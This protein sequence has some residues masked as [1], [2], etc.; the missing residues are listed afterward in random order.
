MTINHSFTLQVYTR[1]N[2]LNITICY[3]TLLKIVDE[4]SK[5]H[6]KP[7]S[8]WLQEGAYVKFVGDNVDKKQTVRDIRSDH[9]STLHH[10]YSMLAIKAR[11]IPPPPSS[12]FVQPKLTVFPAQT[13]LPTPSDVHQLK[14]NLTILVSCILCEHFTQFR[15]M[16]KHVPKH[17][18]HTYS[19]EMSQQSDT[20]VID[21]LHKN[22]AKHNDMLA[23]MTTMQS[24]LGEHR[25]GVLSGGDQLTCERQRGSKRHVMDGDTPKDRLDVLHP[26]IEDWHALQ[27]FLKVHYL[28]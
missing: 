9:H 25:D 15:P 21:V 10:M 27:C 18:Y 28:K 8:K 3:N 22:E 11:A 23:I 26:V 1:F 17:I 12:P 5:H 13:F 4:I 20:V 2:H 7:L 14:H 6:L 19:Q 16:S 24:Y